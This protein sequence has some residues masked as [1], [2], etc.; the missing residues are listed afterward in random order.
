MSTGSSGPAFET[1]LSR[2]EIAAANELTRRWLDSRTEIP[3]A[4]SALGIWP[5]LTALA[6]GASG[7]TRNE[8]LAAAGIAPSREVELAEALLNA[9]AHAPGIRLA[10]GAWA[11]AAITLDP[12]WIEKQPVDSIG[13]LTGDRGIDGPMLDAWASHHTDGLIERMPIELDSDIV[14]I[15][16]SALLVRTTWATEFTE[17][18]THFK[19]G[20]WAGERRYAGL[21][22]TI[23]GDV[24]RVSE[25]GSVLT[26][27][28][29]DDIDVL[30]AL[31]HAEFA[32]RDVMSVLIDAATDPTW[33]RSASE[34]QA[35]KRAPGVRIET[36]PSATPQEGPEVRVETVR[37]DVSAELD[38]S[39]DAAALG[40]V[41][42]M[43]DDR[44]QFD[45]L[46]AD[47][48][49]VSR[50]KQACTATFG[51]KGFESAAVTAMTIDWMGAPQMNH[52][53]VRAV[54]T[55]DRPFA[56]LA[57]HR[58]SGLILVAGWVDEPE[59]VG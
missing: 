55:F 51:P 5:L 44:A 49:F 32:P 11:R 20:P 1:L 6:S 37:F 45:R 17:G 24:L 23:E 56:F 31:G 33:G 48:V 50:A 38:L 54:V 15:L 36:Y 39:E 25:Y 43:D 40:L 9:V 13:S 3:G 4:A 21:S 26:V 53:R 18:A 57:R 58:P 27:P 41:T 30:L 28:G 10:I 7:E 59:V 16:A 29:S 34:R 19:T 2:D 8:L 42:A 12:E 22:N 35:A 47:D 14:L 52:H 46:A